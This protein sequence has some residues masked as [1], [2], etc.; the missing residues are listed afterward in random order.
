MLLTIAIRFVSSDLSNFFDNSSDKSFIFVAQTLA[1]LFNV[2]FHSVGNSLR[3]NQSK[4]LSP[5]SLL[6]SS[7]SFTYPSASLTLSPSEP[8]ESS[9][10]SPSD[11]SSE[12]LSDLLSSSLPLLSTVIPPIEILYENLLRFWEFD[13]LFLFCTFLVFVFLFSMLFVFDALSMLFLS[14]FRSGFVPLETA[15]S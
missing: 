2:I 9:V 1:A 7:V 5:L 3:S 13:G 11:C 6:E 14:G 4:P 12:S 8:S 10:V 15:L